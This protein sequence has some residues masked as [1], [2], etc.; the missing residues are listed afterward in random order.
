MK[1]LFNE[2]AYGEGP[3]AGCWWDET[4]EI[5]AQPEFSAAARTDVAIIG[6][7]FTG[8]TAALFLAR[9]GITVTVLEAQ[10]IG[11]GASGRNGGFCCLG[12]GIAD[13]AALDSRF[14]TKG[15]VEFRRTEV[16]AIQFVESIIEENTI[17]VDRHSHGETSL[18]HRPKDLDALKTHAG[19][20][21][22]NYGVPHQIHS[23]EDL[24]PM[25]MAGPFHGGLTVEAGFGLN[26]RKYIRGLARATTA[27]GAQIFE[28]SL[29]TSMDNR[30]DGWALK[31]NGHTLKADQVIL[32]TNGYSSENLP[33]WL[34]GRY[35]P[36]QSNV[37]VT[38][39]LS[40][41][42]LAEAGWTSEQMAY[43]TRNL[44]HYFRLMPDRR[45]LFGMRGGLRSGAK[46]E[47]KAKAK[48]RTE[49]DAM[50]PAW[51]TVEAAHGWSGMVCLARDLM[52]FVGQVPD[53]R[54]LWAGMCYHGNGVAMGS[55][56]GALLAQLVQ[57][58]TP[59]LIYPETIRQPLRRFELGRWRR[60]VM[61]FAYA[62]FMLAD[63]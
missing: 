31:V 30:I 26:P 44:L 8:L 57:E 12:G 49:F 27:A 56:S 46:A 9:A 47:A 25:G 15:R 7:G 14:G 1:R 10:R 16:A 11:W 2:Y 23:A 34:A 21:A 45:F 22:E 53:Q 40:D 42:E 37:I 28:K 36:S 6:A 63:R 32:A 43:D 39:P 17:D 59:D 29:V 5:P 55:Y 62:A 24:A 3:R 58:K 41:D 35:M 19:S 20:I 13:D 61:P 50:F 48:I 51:Q 52:P 38:R 54:G 33:D 4:C 18:A 60:A